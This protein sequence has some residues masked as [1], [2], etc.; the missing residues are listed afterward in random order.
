MWVLADPVRHLFTKILTY[1]CIH[2][3]TIEQ[4]PLISSFKFK[5]E[6]GINKKNDGVTA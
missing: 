2:N 1:I 5:N 3:T 6:V 4:S